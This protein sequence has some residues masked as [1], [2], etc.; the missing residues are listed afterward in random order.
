M[1]NSSNKQRPR[2]GTKPVVINFKAAT[3]QEE[4][5]S[6]LPDDISHSDT[7]EIVFF[8]IL[9]ISLNKKSFNLLNHLNQRRK[10]GETELKALAN[11]I[12]VNTNLTAL[13]VSVIFNYLPL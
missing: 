4:N 13:T 7:I 6:L 2:Q 11:A 10:I 1:G 12:N 5:K 3:E 9:M 8:S